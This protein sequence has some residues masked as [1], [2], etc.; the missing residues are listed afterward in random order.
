[1]DE[2][3]KLQM[4]EPGDRRIPFTQMC[5][6]KQTKLIYANIIRKV[7]WDVAEGSG[8]GWFDYDFWKGRLRTFLEEWAISFRGQ[9]YTISKP[10]TNT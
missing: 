5:T 2:F 3:Q 7:I 1:M 9:A 10:K 6:N 4:K 8:W